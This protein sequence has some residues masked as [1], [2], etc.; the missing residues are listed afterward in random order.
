[1]KKKLV[2]FIILIFSITS[3]AAPA[4]GGAGPGA[5]SEEAGEDSARAWGGSF[6]GL[7]PYR[8]PKSLR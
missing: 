5:A 7:R 3:C 4:E 6:E 2:Y 8:G 1:M